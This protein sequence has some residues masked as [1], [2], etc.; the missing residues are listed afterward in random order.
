[1]REI[2][3]RAW[4]Q[5]TTGATKEMLDWENYADTITKAIAQPRDTVIIMQFT[6]LK[7]K[8][9]TEIY[10][11]DIIEYRKQ[12]LVSQRSLVDRR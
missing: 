1:M 4:V 2:K 11:G 7:D 10:E 3:F 12:S 5:T 6:G 9:G 8:N